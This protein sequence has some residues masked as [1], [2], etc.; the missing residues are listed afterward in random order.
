MAS[1]I[2]ELV[3]QRAHGT[4]FQAPYWQCDGCQQRVDIEHP[5]QAYYWSGTD[6]AWLKRP[7]PFGIFHV[8]CVTDAMA[9]YPSDDLDELVRDLQITTGI[10]PDVTDRKVSRSREV[11][12][13]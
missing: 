7:G 8:A 4:A 13:F 11:L 9:E 1:I 5:A 12:G 2:W 3:E 6:D 10:P